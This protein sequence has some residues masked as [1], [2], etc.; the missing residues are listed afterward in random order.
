[1]KYL[2]Q[3]HS[4]ITTE[5]GRCLSRSVDMQSFQQGL[6]NIFSSDMDIQSLQ[7][8]LVDVCSSSADIQSLQQGLVNIFSSDMDIQ[9]LQ[10]R[11][12]DVCSSSVD[13][14]LLQKGLVNIFSY[15]MDIQS[16]QQGLADVSLLT[17]TCKHHNRDRNVRS[18]F[19]IFFLFC[20][21]LI[22]SPITSCWSIFVKTLPSSLLVPTFLPGV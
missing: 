5:T 3:R 19:N 6:V 1:M 4:I 8:R 11:L 20:R 12:E 21:G 10:Q 18:F 9:S 16:S 17:E 15:G 2:F 13:M 14:Q 7:Q 22:M